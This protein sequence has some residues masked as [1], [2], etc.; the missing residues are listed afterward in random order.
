MYII[1]ILMSATFYIKH[2]SNLHVFTYN[3]LLI[4]LSAV[5]ATLGEECL[6]RQN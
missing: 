5:F 6:L 3:I 2:S 4:K 1:V